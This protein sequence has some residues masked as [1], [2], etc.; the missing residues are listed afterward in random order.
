MFQLSDLKAEIMLLQS[1]DEG[2]STLSQELKSKVCQLK[3]KD[4]SIKSFVKEINILNKY[5]DEL[6]LENEIMRY[7][8]PSI[9]L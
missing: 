9:W 5:V 4:G 1:T 3:A 8:D 2:I 6:Q 7:V